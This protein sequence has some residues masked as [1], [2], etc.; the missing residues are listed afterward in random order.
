MQVLWLVQFY[1][2]VS[3]LQIAQPFDFSHKGICF[4]PLCQHFPTFCPWKAF[5][6]GQSQVAGPIEWGLWALFGQQAMLWEPLL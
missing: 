4:I 1:F 5:L 6:K 3:D 2:Q